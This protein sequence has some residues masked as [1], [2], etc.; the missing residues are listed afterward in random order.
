MMKP[1]LRQARGDETTPFTLSL[2]KR[3]PVEAWKGTLLK[4]RNFPHL[5][6]DTSE[7][8]M[9][10]RG[11]FLV[12]GAG[13]VLACGFEAEAQ[14]RRHASRLVASS[15]AN[16]PLD[17]GSDVNV[18]EFEASPAAISPDLLAGLPGW[19]APKTQRPHHTLPDLLPVT[20]QGTVPKPLGSPGSCEAQ[21]FG[22]G[23]CGYTASRTWNGAKR[24]DQTD[25]ANTPSAAWLY[26]YAHSQE[27]RSCPTGS[28]AVVYL[29]QMIRDGAPSQKSVPYTTVCA[30][31]DSDYEKPLSRFPE[32]KGLRIG[33]FATFELAKVDVDFLK[34]YLAAGH[35]IAFSGP[36]ASGYAAPKLT[37]GVFTAAGCTWKG[38]HGQVIVGYDDAKGG[39]AFLV[40]NS[41]G[42]QWGAGGRLWW[43]YDTLMQHQKL[44][45]IAFPRATAL[46]GTA[47]HAA[48][49][50]APRGTVAGAKR[51]AGH[52]LLALQFADTVEI[53]SISASVANGPKGT[54]T[55]NAPFAAGIVQI[56][57]SG[58][59]GGSCSVTVA[60]TTLSGTSAAYTGTI[61]LS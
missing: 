27:H 40:Q 38:G 37:N 35:A 3:E 57:L 33:S 48:A 58:S 20:Q 59:A 29:Q 19:N 43:A 8:R 2:S 34:A 54:L 24:W 6:A 21:S 60:A 31:L 5:P 22:H 18:A 52:A 17:P 56:P 53:A 30:T 28:G 9:I 12:A 25:P 50:G 36:V 51:V 61:Q 32:A 44:A 55:Y 1:A 14:Q 49:S 23:L 26:S 39:G 45:A 47:L 4:L 11:R 13:A 10:R 7:V 46:T 16:Q 15:L 41:F 42:T